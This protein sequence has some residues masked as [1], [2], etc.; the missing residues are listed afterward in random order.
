MNG[1]CNALARLVYH[2]NLHRLWAPAYR[3]SAKAG[4]RVI[5]TAR[6]VSQLSR[7]AQQYNANQDSRRV[8]AELKAD[9]LIVENAPTPA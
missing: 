6:D 5:A 3:R 7:L 1:R 9:K 4:E 2:G 8:W